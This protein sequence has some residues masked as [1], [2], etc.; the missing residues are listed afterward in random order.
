[1]FSGVPVRIRLCPAPADAGVAFVRTD[2]PGRPRIPVHIDHLSA[3]PRRTAVARENAE[4]ETIEHLMSAVHGLAVDNLDI[5]IN[6]PEVPGVDGS[7]APFA[8]LLRGAELVDLDAPRFVFAPREPVSVV[9]DDSSLVAMP[10]KRGLSVSFTLD[11]QLSYF[12]PQH[13]TIDVG[14]DRYL[15]EIA[16]SR[17]FCLQSEV[18]AL[19]DQGM[20][21]GAS[22]QN[23]L[24]I[25]PEGVIQNE[26]RF[27]DEFVRHKILDLIG[28][29]ALLGC[30]LQ[31]HVVA[32][33]AGH[34]SNARL[35][36]AL[37]KALADQSARRKQET[38]LDVRE[39]L[40]ILPHRY[41]FLLIDKVIE[42][43]SYKK[44]TGIKNVTYNEP[45]FQGHFPG[46]PIMPGVLQIEAMAQLAGALLLR[47]AENA[48]KLAVLLSIDKVKLRKT[49]V[50]GDQLRIEA[51]AERV[52]NRTGF[53]HTWCTVEGKLVCEAY[54]KFM[55]V[56]P[57]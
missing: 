17:T 14:E 29:L 44:A 56:D 32:I 10:S 19:L 47:K 52:K 50:P 41:P 22:Y 21:K 12:G 13:Y 38:F 26:V 18:K 8:E 28:D 43:D 4:V 34:A 31:A 33:R 48:N 35:V 11:Y 27:K 30:P 45:F 57:E 39:I 20:G 54:M 51:E 6:A 49:V 9:D 42:L 40:K 53:V 15:R 16:P 55:L 7:A 37:Q 25:G 36:R 1:M 46:Q 2:L 3:K 5:E 24:V 23:T